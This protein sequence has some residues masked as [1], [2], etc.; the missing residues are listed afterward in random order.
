MMLSLMVVV[1]GGVG[2]GVCCDGV[3]VGEG[4]ADTSLSLNASL[5]STEGRTLALYLP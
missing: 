1:R 2:V 5:V 3:L 4:N